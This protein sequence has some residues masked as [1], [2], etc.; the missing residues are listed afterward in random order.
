[1]ANAG[2]FAWTTGTL[3]ISVALLG[4]SYPRMTT[5]SDYGVRDG[6]AEPAESMYADRAAVAFRGKPCLRHR[7]SF[8]SESLH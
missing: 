4:I 2:K 7:Y 8:R 6:K 5:G 3:E 1:M